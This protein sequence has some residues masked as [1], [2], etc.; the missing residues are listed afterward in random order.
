VSAARLLGLLSGGAALGAAYLLHRKAEQT[1]EQTMQAVATGGTFAVRLTGYWPFTASASE[2]KMEGGA[3][4]RKGKPL[5]TLEDFQ[6]G[7]APYVSVSGDDAIF[8]Y[9]QRIAIDEWPG[10]VF[11]VVDT[12]GHFRGSGKVYRAVG[13]E[14]LDICV[15]SSK[16]HVVPLSTATIVKGDH[17]DKPGKEVEVARMQGQSVAVGGAFDLIGAEVVQTGGEG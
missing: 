16:T 3:N 13:H 8:P 6:A 14:P 12:G 9:G 5:H 2:K 4:D 1:R 7:T 10:V 15:Q 11:R 17:F